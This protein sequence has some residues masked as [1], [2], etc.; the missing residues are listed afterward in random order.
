MFQK[1]SKTKQKLGYRSLSECVMDYLKE[2]LNTGELNP[3]DEINVTELLE[4]L[5]VSRTPIREAL[6]QLKKDG[7]IENVSRK[8]FRIKKLSIDEIEYIYQIIGLLESEAVKITCD[9]ITE[10]EILELQENYEMMKKALADNDFSSYLNLNDSCH[11]LFIKYCNNPILLS[12]I[13]N[14]KERLY[15]FPKIILNISEW[16]NMMMSDHQQII[17]LFKKRDK[18][19]LVKLIKNTHWDFKRNYPYILKYYNIKSE[20]GSLK[21]VE[22]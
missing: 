21:E 11:R 17:Q 9:K 1:N 3:G 19:G 22:K 7:Y 10:E 20:N 15:E 18:E 14:L 13:E 2:K 16:E 12:I 8:E 5:G 6:I 4:T